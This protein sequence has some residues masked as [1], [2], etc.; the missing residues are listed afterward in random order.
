MVVT[1][2]VYTYIG[3]VAETLNEG[4]PRAAWVIIGDRSSRE[5]PARLRL[6]T[7]LILVQAILGALMSIVF[8]GAAN[9]FASA[10][11]PPRARA[12]SLAYVRISSF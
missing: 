10:F 4:L 2:D 5:W 12:T 1:T 7:T 8:A 6:A 3:V 11:I 9:D